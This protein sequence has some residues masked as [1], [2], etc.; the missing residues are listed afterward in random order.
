MCH[1]LRNPLMV[2]RG[3]AQ[4][5][6]RAILRSTGLPEAERVGILHSLAAIEAAVLRMVEMVEDKSPSRLIGNT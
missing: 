3:R 5:V 4:L 2:I 6:E 1:D